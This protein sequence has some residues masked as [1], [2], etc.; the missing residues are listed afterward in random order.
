MRAIHD[1]YPYID[2]HKGL[3]HILTT[4]KECLAFE[5]SHE[6]AVRLKWDEKYKDEYFLSGA[7]QEAIRNC[8]P[9]LGENGIP[10]PLVYIHWTIEETIHPRFPIYYC[11]EAF[12]KSVYY[13]TDIA[14][15]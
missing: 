8:I 11:W 6:N 15:S 10:H 4:E 13:F 12:S 1:W 14:E 2:K 9:K 3:V 7:Y 5:K